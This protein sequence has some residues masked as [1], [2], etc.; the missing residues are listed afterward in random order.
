MSLC[1]NAVRKGMQDHKIAFNKPR[2]LKGLNVT[3]RNG[4]KWKEKVNPGDTLLLVDNTGIVFNNGR[5]L[6]TEIFNA[7]K[8]QYQIEYL[9]K[10]EHDPDCRNWNG[11]VK[12]LNDAYGKN[13][14]GPNVTV[15]LFWIDDVD[16]NNHSSHSEKNY[17]NTK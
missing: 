10:W 17:R 11:L 14:W 4:E 7:K 9:L 15:L 16:P 12:S 13:N 2:V 3:I 8:F 6:T 1:E 5:V